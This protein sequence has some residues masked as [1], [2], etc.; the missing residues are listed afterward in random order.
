MKSIFETEIQSL[1]QQLEN[2]SHQLHSL[3]KAQTIADTTLT[4]FD[5]CLDTLTSLGDKALEKFWTQILLRRNQENNPENHSLDKQETE[6]TTPTDTQ[7][8]LNINE[9]TTS[10]IGSSEPEIEDKTVENQPIFTTGDTV[11][12]THP[13]ALPE[14]KQLHWQVVGIKAYFHEEDE[15]VMVV[16]Q[17]PE[18]GETS[19]PPEWLSK[20]TKE[21]NQPE[22]TIIECNNTEEIETTELIWLSERIAYNYEPKSQ[23]ILKAYIFGNNQSK[24]ERWAR[25]LAE[26]TTIANQATTEKNTINDQFKYQVTLAGIQLADLQKLTEMNLNT[27]HP[28]SVWGE[29][30]L[31]PIEPACKPSNW[32]KFQLTADLKSIKE[33]EAWET[34]KEEFYQVVNQGDKRQ[35]VLAD[36]NHKILLFWKQGLPTEI[37]PEC[38]QYESGETDLEPENLVAHIDAE[39]KSDSNSSITLNNNTYPSDLSSNK[40]MI[41]D[42]VQIIAGTAKGLSG[43]IQVATNKGGIV[44]TEQGNR[45]V[46]WIDCQVT[47]K[48]LIN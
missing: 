10:K 46:L 40:P 43:K 27:N 3:E 33:F 9:T 20:F 18:K 30:P 21:Q 39:V 17:H 11:Q 6:N 26:T 4:H 47:E 31:R 24:A 44:V 15:A 12:I 42:F 13:N 32:W 8:N 48:L 7:T 45:W 14:H 23:Q 37:S 41:G 5:N 1:K 2:I 28:Y 19:Y 34:A 38:E 35:V 36:S 22:E 29:A 16:I 25:F